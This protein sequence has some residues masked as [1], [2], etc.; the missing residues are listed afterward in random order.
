MKRTMLGTIL[1]MSSMIFGHRGV[2][3]QDRFGSLSN[4]NGHHRTYRPSRMKGKSRRT[5]GRK[6]PKFDF[7]GV[8]GQAGYGMFKNRSTGQVMELR[9]KDPKD[10]R[11]GDYLL[12]RA[13]RIH[14][15]LLKE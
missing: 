8:S 7:M 15:G 14:Y 12:P 2:D 6:P 13:C 10:K 1:A 9:I 3:V 11:T 5:Q 4:L